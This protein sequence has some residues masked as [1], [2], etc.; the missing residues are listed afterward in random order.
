MSIDRVAYALKERGF[1]ARQE[2]DLQYTQ[3]FPV[4]AHD[5]A[6]GDRDSRRLGDPDMLRIRS[7]LVR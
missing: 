5:T 1:H 6:T 3:M 4:Q 7:L 2:N